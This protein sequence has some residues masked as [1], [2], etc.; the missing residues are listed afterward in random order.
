[1]PSSGHGPRLTN[2]ESPAQA[3]V[4]RPRNPHCQPAERSPAVKGGPSGPSTASRAAAPLTD[5]RSV[6]TRVPIACTSSRARENADLQQR[7]GHPAPGRL[8]ITPGNSTSA[9]NTTPTT[10]SHS[11]RTS[12]RAGSCPLSG[13]ELNVPIILDPTVGKEEP[14]E[15]K[16]E[17]DAAAG[18]RDR[19]RVIWSVR[20]T[21]RPVLVWTTSCTCSHTRLLSG[22]SGSAA[23]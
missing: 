14:F 15:T 1:M 17:V 18:S 5:G 22:E 10:S 21:L 23:Q 16:A 4:A 12:R 3:W 13:R 6:A 9:T 19:I 7:R 2:A 8:L 11:T 20:R